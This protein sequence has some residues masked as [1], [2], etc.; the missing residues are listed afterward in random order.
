ML[1]VGQA[2]DGDLEA[3]SIWNDLTESIKAISAEI[4]DPRIAVVI[5]NNLN[6]ENYILMVMD[7]TVLYNIVEEW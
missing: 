3:L 6:K 2:M 5:C 7:G 4:E 1:E